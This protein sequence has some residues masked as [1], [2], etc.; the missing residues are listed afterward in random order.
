[1]YFVITNNDG[2]T[3]VHQ[4]SKEEVLKKLNGEDWGFIPNIMKTIDDPDTNRWEGGAIL[5]IK[6]DIANVSPVETVTEFQID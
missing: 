5:I 4:Y 6:G 1:M 2:D 3:T